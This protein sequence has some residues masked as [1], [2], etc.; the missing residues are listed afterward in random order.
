MLPDSFTQGPG[1]ADADA[2]TQL[3]DSVVD[4]ISGFL[5]RSLLLC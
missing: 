3:R 4:D 5:C 1:A 2:E